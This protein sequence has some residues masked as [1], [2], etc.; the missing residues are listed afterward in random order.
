MTHSWINHVLNKASERLLP[1]E[2]SGHFASEL[3]VPSSAF[4]SFEH[5][6]K[7]ELDNG[8]PLIVLGALLVEDASLASDEIRVIP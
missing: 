3:R 8:L 7:R 5:L 6:R 4:H 1:L 2:E